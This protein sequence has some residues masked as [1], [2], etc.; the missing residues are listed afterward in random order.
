MI[1][2]ITI[3]ITEEKAIVKLLDENGEEMNRSE[4]LPTESGTRTKYKGVDFEDMT[5]EEGMTDE[6]WEALEQSNFMHD[7]LTAMHDKRYN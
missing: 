5:E 6:L 2:K 7:V 3:E 4:T 1:K